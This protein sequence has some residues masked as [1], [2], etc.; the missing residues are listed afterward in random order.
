MLT[1][2]LEVYGITSDQVDLISIVRS[3]E[4]PHCPT[5]AAAVEA[6]LQN[7]TQE[8]STPLAGKK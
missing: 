1:N 5:A 3:N 4:Q 8:R 6:D 2:A 7:L